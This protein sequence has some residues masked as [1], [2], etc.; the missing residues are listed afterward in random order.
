MAVVPAELHST[1]AR[2]I[3]AALKEALGAALLALGLSVPILALRTEQ[4]ISNQLM[5]Q[6]RWDYVAIAV[7]A[8]F[9]G[10]LAL[11]RLRRGLRA[12]RPA[13]RRRAA[14]IPPA[15]LT[16]LVS[17]VG[18]IVAAALPVDRA[19]PHRPRRRHQMDR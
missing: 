10:R 11:S 8:A 6:P 14:W 5:L 12:P 3:T 15:G 19:R 4:D 9:F 2:P 13:R 1:S 16:R 7:L 18:L 17:I